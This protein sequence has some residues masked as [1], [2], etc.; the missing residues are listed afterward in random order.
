MAASALTAVPGPE[1]G[2]Q[3][4]AEALSQVGRPYVWG[5][6]TPAPGFDCSGLMRYVVKRIAGVD[7]THV[8]AYQAQAGSPV[9]RDDLQIGDMVFFKDTYKPGLSHVGFYLGNGQFV[10]AQ[11]ERVGVARASLDQRY[12]H[13]RYYGA[14]RLSD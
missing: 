7:I 11:N 4:A 5:G 8:L 10:S 2:R 13:S 14:R 3:Y 1:T 6:E 9:E 12:W